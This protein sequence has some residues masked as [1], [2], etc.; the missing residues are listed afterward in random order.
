MASLGLVE[1]R[2]L[3]VLAER[4]LSGRYRDKSHTEVA[5][6]GCHTA[7]DKAQD[8][9]TPGLHPPAL[10]SHRHQTSC[11]SHP[12]GPLTCSQYVGPTHSFFEIVEF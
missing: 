10:H 4:S 2:D 5:G 7:E 6:R 11:S 1:A 12:G 9:L 8:D 3:F